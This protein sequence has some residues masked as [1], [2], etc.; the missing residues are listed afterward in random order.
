MTSTNLSDRPTDQMPSVVA[1]EIFTETLSAMGGYA[2]L[3]QS[4]GLTPSYLC[5]GIEGELIMRFNGCQHTNKVK[6]ELSEIDT[7]TLSFYKFSFALEN[8]GCQL[9]EVFEDVGR[10]QLQHSFE[11]FTG[12]SL[13]S[14]EFSDY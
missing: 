1:N 8:R 3:K 4:L 11:E 14:K 7:Y 2:L 10:E 13:V 6:V 5:R 9:V 12:L